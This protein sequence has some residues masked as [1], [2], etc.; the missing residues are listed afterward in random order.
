M[1]CSMTRLRDRLVRTQIWIILNVMALEF[2]INWFALED[3]SLG[4]NIVFGKC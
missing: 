2:S 4:W 3:L 1:N